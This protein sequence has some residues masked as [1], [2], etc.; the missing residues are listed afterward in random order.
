MVVAHGGLRDRRPGVGVATREGRRQS[1]GWS[2]VLITL[3]LEPTLM[4]PEMSGT[5]AS[6]INSSVDVKLEPTWT[7]KELSGTQTSVLNSMSEHAKTF[8]T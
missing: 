4:V 8:N 1:T 2:V 6:G 7:V 5:Q 3:K